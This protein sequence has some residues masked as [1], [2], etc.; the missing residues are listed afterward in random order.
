MQLEEYLINNKLNLFVNNYE[1]IKETKGAW[2]MGMMKYS[3]ALSAAIKNQ[4]INPYKIEEA[5]DLIKT[6][7]GICSSFRGHSMPYLSTILSNNNNSEASLK[8]ILNIYDKLK[9][10]RFHNDTYLVFVAIIIQQYKHK[11]D[12]D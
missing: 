6:N 1:N 9:E 8:S 5:M 4:N 12:V 7:T 11:M 3:C 2:N 10:N